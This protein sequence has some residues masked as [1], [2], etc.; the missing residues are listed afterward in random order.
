MDAREYLGQIE[1]INIRIQQKQGSLSELQKR[2][3]SQKAAG[4]A[5]DK[6]RAE[7]D[8]LEAERS[9]IIDTIY[10]LDNPNQI[11]ILCGKWVKGLKLEDVAR[12]MSYNFDY[13][14]RVHGQGMRKMQE[15][16]DKK[17]H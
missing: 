1:T 14:R 8:A 3:D 15:I 2:G 7:I 12:N 6:I 10:S 11:K 4:A 13:V 9:M 16:L 17:T 5:A